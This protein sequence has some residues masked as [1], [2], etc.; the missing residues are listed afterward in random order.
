MRQK[1]MKQIWELRDEAAAADDLETVA[2]CDAAIFGNAHAM[3]QC[4][5]I[6]GAADAMHDDDCEGWDP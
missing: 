5:A 1:T 6:M 3:A 4:L 2:L